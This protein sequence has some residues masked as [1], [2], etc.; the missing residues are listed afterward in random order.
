MDFL[1][2]KIA[3]LRGLADGLEVKDDTREGKLFNALMDVIEE[4][5]DSMSDMIEEQDEVNEYLD[6]L[7]EDLSVVE[8]EIFGDLELYEDDDDYDFDFDEDDDDDYED[9]FEIEEHPCD[10]SKLED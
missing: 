1:Y 8:E 7:D 6:L 5:A 10:C 4:I 9:D 2:E 3:Y